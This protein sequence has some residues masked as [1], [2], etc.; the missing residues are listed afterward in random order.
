MQK[1]KRCENFL[2]QL[3]VQGECGV[4]AAKRSTETK[5]ENEL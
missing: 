4:H 2:Q 5:G 1:V 3:Y